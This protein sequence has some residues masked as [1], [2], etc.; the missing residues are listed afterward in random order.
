MRHVTRGGDVV[1]GADSD[2]AVGVRQPA[3][4]RVMK[5]FLVSVVLA[6]FLACAWLPGALALLTPTPA[7][8]RTHGEHHCSDLQT[9][10]GH[11]MAATCPLRGG[12]FAVAASD[13]L[14]ETRQH[15][16][17]TGSYV[18]RFHLHVSRLT[19]VA[20]QP[21]GRSPPSFLV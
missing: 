3:T 20:L 17:E 7:C 8:C 18:F 11:S 10:D 16:Y 14:P 9:D 6:A 12:S 21:S 1:G 15:G 19:T 4:R 13:A 5:K 2:V